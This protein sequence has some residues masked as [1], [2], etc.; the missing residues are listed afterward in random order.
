MP[1]LKTNRAAKKRFKVL[2]SGKIK[3]R[4]AMLRHILTSKAKGRKQK[5]RRG[6]LIHAADVNEIKRLLP[7]S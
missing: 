3:R 7:Y 6:T 5:L 2:K 1:K 4:R